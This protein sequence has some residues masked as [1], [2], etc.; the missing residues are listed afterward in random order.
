MIV[1]FDWRPLWG[2]STQITIHLGDRPFWWTS[3][4]RT[5]YF[6]DRLETLSAQHNLQRFFDKLD[7]YFDMF[8]LCDTF[9]FFDNRKIQI[10][11][12]WQTNPL[13]T[14]HYS[15]CLRN[16]THIKR[17]RNRFH[18]SPNF[19]RNCHFRVKKLENFD[20]VKKVEIEENWAGFKS[21]WISTSGEDFKNF[22][23]FSNSD[24]AILIYVKVKFSKIKK[25]WFN[26]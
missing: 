21:I 19:G 25:T 7:R 6:E 26:Q 4:L 22:F 14:I 2:V 20:M 15:N 12:R 17:T 24:P 23:D 1:Y 3:T 18:F 8:F 13:D 5:V 10:A 11:I 16:F 9:C